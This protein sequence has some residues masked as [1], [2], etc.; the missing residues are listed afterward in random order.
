MNNKIEIKP[1]LFKNCDCEQEVL[2]FL[3]KEL[4]NENLAEENR[5]TNSIKS[6][7][8]KTVLNYQIAMINLTLGFECSKFNY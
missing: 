5:G 3:K 6:S 4:E 7:D 2:N 8:Y 1:Y